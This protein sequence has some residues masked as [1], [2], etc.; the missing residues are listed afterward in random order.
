MAGLLHHQ[1][2]HILHTS[3][4]HNCFKATASQDCHID[5]G[6]FQP[7][8]LLPLLQPPY[9]GS[10]KSEHLHFFAATIF[11]C[12][13]CTLLC[14]KYFFR[15]FSDQRLFTSLRRTF[16]SG[17]CP[18]FVMF[19]AAALRCVGGC[20]ARSLY[21][22]F[23]CISTN[24]LPDCFPTVAVNIRGVLKIFGLAEH[25][26]T[27]PHVEPSPPH[28]LQPYLIC[29]KNF[30]ATDSA[31]FTNCVTDSCW[32][33]FAPTQILLEKPRSFEFSQFRP[34]GLKLADHRV[35]L[36]WHG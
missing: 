28:F 4:L 18:Y 7:L 35:Q 19:S 3:M 33:F 16:T 12:C 2:P 15:F 20:L 25:E 34:I 31:Q 29:P 22:L 26:S 5:T 10:R 1:N 24:F 17:R 21:P 8:F 13:R 30:S 14:S 27:S 9:S 32:Q 23:L 36:P 6:D 11:A